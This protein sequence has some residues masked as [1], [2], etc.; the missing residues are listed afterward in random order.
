MLLSETYPSE[1]GTYSDPKVMSSMAG[2]YIGTEFTHNKKSDCAGMVE[3]GSRES[4][5]YKTREQAEKELELGWDQ[6]DNP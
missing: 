4:G 2:Y 3:P 6:R 5:Y 1:E